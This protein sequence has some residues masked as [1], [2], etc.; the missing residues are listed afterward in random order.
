MNI[1]LTKRKKK[2]FFKHK[3]E[4]KKLIEFMIKNLCLIFEI[5]NIHNY[6]Y[7]LYFDATPIF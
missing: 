1:Y 2:E 4:V 5:F 6:I 3:L 7:L